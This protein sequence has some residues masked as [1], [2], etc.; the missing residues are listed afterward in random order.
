[1][2]ESSCVRTKSLNYI[3]TLVNM[4][5]SEADVQVKENKMS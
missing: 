3:K 1:M 5:L 2:M 4:L